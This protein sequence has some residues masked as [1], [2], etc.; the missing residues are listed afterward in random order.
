MAE[1]WSV[2]TTWWQ[3][4][5]TVPSDWNNDNIVLNFDAVDQEATVFL[6]VSKSSAISPDTEVQGHNVTFH[7]GG[8]I[9]FAIDVTQYVNRNGQNELLVF[10]HDPTNAPGY[11]SPSASFARKS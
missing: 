1:G 8:Y 9:R 4:N 7:R 5:F 3:T 6:N 10:V 11:V 2:L